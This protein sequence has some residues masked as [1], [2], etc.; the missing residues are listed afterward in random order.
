MKSIFIMAMMSLLFGLNA[1]ASYKA[2]VLA[3]WF[4]LG[5][6]QGIDEDGR[7]CEVIMNS[8]L[9]LNSLNLNLEGVELHKIPRFN[10]YLSNELKEI[11]ETPTSLHIVLKS[12]P[13]NSYTSA[14]IQ[15]LNVTKTSQG[16]EVS[17]KEKEARLFGRTNKGTCIIK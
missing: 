14:M 17:L 1:Q 11:Q 13:S 8:S 15:T 6:T 3:N 16:T 12:N 9:G 7:S 2:E 4:E 10:S 5:R